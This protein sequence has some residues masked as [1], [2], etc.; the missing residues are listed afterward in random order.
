[1]HDARSSGLLAKDFRPDPIRYNLT[2]LRNS[3][4]PNLV[5]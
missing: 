3:F 4:I 1:L 5:L 2:A